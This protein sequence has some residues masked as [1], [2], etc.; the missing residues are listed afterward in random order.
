MAYHG[1]R[2]GTARPG[3]KS[4]VPRLPASLVVGSGSMK[5]CLCVCVCVCVCVC[6]GAYKEWGAV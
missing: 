1:E 2:E 5:L 6:K 4:S 3:R